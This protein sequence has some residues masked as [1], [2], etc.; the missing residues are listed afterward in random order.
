MEDTASYACVANHSV[1]GDSPISGYFCDCKWSYEDEDG[2]FY[3]GNPYINGGCPE[4]EPP[5]EP[6]PPPPPAGQF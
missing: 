1:C 6:P 3:A 2:N 4:Y 5:S